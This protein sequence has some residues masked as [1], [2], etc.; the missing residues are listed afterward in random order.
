MKDL[1]IKYPKTISTS[2][3]KSVQIFESFYGED[4]MWEVTE[5]VHGANFQIIYD[6]ENDK[7]GFASRNQYLGSEDN[8][9]DISFFNIN[10]GLLES[11]ISSIKIN[12]DFIF[13]FCRHLTPLN[14]DGREP[15]KVINIYGELY[16]GGGKGVEDSCIQS[17]LKYTDTHSFRAF[18][19]RV[20]GKF[21]TC[22]ELSIF[23]HNTG[24]LNMESLFEGTLKECLEFETKFK[25][26]YS[27]HNV[28]NEGVVIKPKETIFKIGSNY[29]FLK[30]VNDDF[31]EINSAK[32]PKPVKI[33][34]NIELALQET[35]R[36]YVN[37]N[38][39]DSAI[40]KLGKDNVGAIF[41]EVSSDVLEEM[42]GDALAE[43]TKDEISLIN[44]TVSSEARDSILE[45]CQE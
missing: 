8:Y 45:S 20:N 15:L 25:S 14:E 4:S 7:V 40:S 38:R 36:S 28:N 43:F 32:K 26:K 23:C 27:P 29:P 39:I 16:G 30:T 37:Q 21:S 22:Q 5:K 24:I 9:K 44:K 3:A 33:L 41:K 18:A 2:K 12:I 13:T 11:I 34:T 35:A 17:K 6:V 42:Q 1:F 10:K 19:L 31:K